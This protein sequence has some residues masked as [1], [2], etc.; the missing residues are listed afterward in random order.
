MTQAPGREPQLLL[1]TNLTH[2][3]P[4]REHCNAAVC[5]L[6]SLAQ[7]RTPFERL[8]RRFPPICASHIVV[9][10]KQ[11]H[12]S[13]QTNLSQSCNFLSS[14]PWCRGRDT[15]CGSSTSSRRL[16]W[17][18]RG[19]RPA[20]SSWWTPPPGDRSSNPTCLHAHRP[21]P[22]GTR[23]NLWATTCTP[24]GVVLCSLMIL[25]GPSPACLTGGR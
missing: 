13:T 23:A 7:R 11:P 15:G 3:H 10:C 2:R 24:S 20:D 17:R 6:P 5:S 21:G 9:A 1:G 8:T 18:R 12:N 16:A 14:P 4:A 22:L 25:S 19:R